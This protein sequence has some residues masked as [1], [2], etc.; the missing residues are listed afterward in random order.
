MVTLNSTVEMRFISGLHPGVVYNFTV[1]ATNEIGVSRP[2]DITGLPT[3]D[4]GKS[5]STGY[6]AL[7][8]R[9]DPLLN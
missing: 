2:S 7:N 9:H 3:H 5:V 8:M 1:V 6:N 4:E